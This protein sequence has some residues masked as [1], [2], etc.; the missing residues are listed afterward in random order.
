MSRNQALS[1]AVLAAALTLATG[2]A[3]CGKQGVL[4]QPAPLFGSKAKAD[5]A[6]QKAQ[7]ARDAAQRKEIEREGSAVSSS[8]PTTVDNAPLTRRDIQDPNQKLSPASS[9]PILGAPNLMGSPVQTTN[10]Y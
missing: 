9:S 8:G 5:Y 3:G 2:L 4:Q 6:A 1:R 10:P 7:E